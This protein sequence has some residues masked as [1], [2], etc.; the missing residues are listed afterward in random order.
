[1]W[2]TDGARKTMVRARAVFNGSRWIAPL[3]TVVGI[4]GCGSQ[5]ARGHVPASRASAIAGAREFARK[6]NLPTSEAP[7]GTTRRSA[8]REAPEVGGSLAS[9][10]RVNA[11]LLEGAWQ[12]PVYVTPITG[13][14]LKGYLEVYSWIEVFGDRSQAVAAERLLLSGSGVRCVVKA[15]LTHQRELVAKRARIESSV[16]RT[17]VRA[18]DIDGHAYVAFETEEAITAAGGLPGINGVR[19]YEMALSFV[20][21]GA[22]VGLFAKTFGGPPSA[23]LI[24][25]LVLG[26]AARAGSGP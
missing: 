12:S 8:E 15:A 11:D 18:I 14:S 26:L 13:L 10:A 4:C 24:R 17:D 6:V 21:G 7:A 5:G 19:G 9:C 23:S 1:M 20:A 22:R 3:L 2:P 16:P 25:N